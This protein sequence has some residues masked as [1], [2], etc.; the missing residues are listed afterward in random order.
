MIHR[1]GAVTSLYR[2]FDDG[3]D[4]LVFQVNQLLADATIAISHAT[5]DLYRQ[6]GIELVSPRVIYK[7]AIRTLPRRQPETVD[8]NRKIRLIATSWSDNVNKGAPV[9][10]G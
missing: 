8:R 10:R 4:Q 2:G 3:T 9:Y 5:L 1:V 6:I 7:A